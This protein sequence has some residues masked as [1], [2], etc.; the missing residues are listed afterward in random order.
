MP[1]SS[2]LTIGDLTVD[3]SKKEKSV[4]RFLRYRKSLVKRDIHFEFISYEDVLSGKLPRIPT[5]KLK[6]M[7]FFPYAYWNDNIERYDTD[8]RVYGDQYFGRIYSAFFKRIDR[9]LKEGYSKRSISYVNPPEACALDRNKEKTARLLRK[10]GILTPKKFNISELNDLDKILQKAGALYVKP[11]F[12]SMGKGI[13]FLTRGECWTNFDY[14]HGNIVSKPYD[15]NWDFVKIAGKKRTG[16]LNA[17]IKKGFIF[18]EAIK[19]PT[20]KRRKFDIRIYVICGK[21]PYFYAR[22]APQRSVVTNWSQGGRIEQS[23]FL[24]NILPQKKIKEIKEIA[25]RVAS[26]MSLNYVGIDLMLDERFDRI[27]FLEAHSFPGYEKGF[28]LMKFLVGHIKT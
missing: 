5:K 25:R 6:I 1:R 28:N 23:N 19:L 14:N 13:S 9:I 18:E 20:V 2:L 27:Y 8:D 26:S 17:L 21:V 24:E 15:Y 11:N 10:E 3:G 22:S 4:R 12:G 16:F 7:F